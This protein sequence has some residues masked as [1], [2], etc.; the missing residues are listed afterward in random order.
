MNYMTM[1][2][3][4]EKIRKYSEAFMIGNEVKTLSV[5]LKAHIDEES[6]ELFLNDLDSILPYGTIFSHEYENGVL[7]IIFKEVA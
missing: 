5:F 4:D 7:N 2:K 1:I 6:K 3:I